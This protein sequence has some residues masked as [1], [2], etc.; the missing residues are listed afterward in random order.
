MNANVKK[1]LTF[2]KKN[3][4]KTSDSIDRVFYRGGRRIGSILKGSMNLFKKIQ[5][6]T[7]LWYSISFRL[8]HYLFRSIT[9]IKS[10]LLKIHTLKKIP[11]S[12]KNRMRDTF[13]NISQLSPQSKKGIKISFIPRKIITQIHTHLH[14]PS[15]VSSFR[16]GLFYHK[17]K[18]LDIVRSFQTIVMSSF[19]LFKKVTE[20]MPSY[21]ILLSK[22]SVTVY[23][24]VC[25][26]FHHLVNSFF[27]VCEKI[28]FSIILLPIL[29][30]FFFIRSIIVG[31][32]SFRKKIFLV[33]SLS[34]SIKNSI[35]IFIEKCKNNLLRIFSF[36]KKNVFTR[37]IPI[38]DE[39]KK[40]KRNFLFQKNTLKNT[41]RFF[42]YYPKK[43]VCS[44]QKKGIHVLKESVSALASF[45][46][47]TQEAFA[48][49]F[50]DILQIR[51][52]FTYLVKY[53]NVTLH[54]PRIFISSVLQENIQAIH[55][56][57]IQPLT[58][59]LVLTKKDFEYFF[60]HVPSFL[61][62]PF[63]KL[64][65]APLR[66][67]NSYQLYI[68]Q[69]QQQQ[70]TP[71][72]APS[73]T[74][75][76]IKLSTSSHFSFFKKHYLTEV[77]TLAVI[78]GSVGVFMSLFAAPTRSSFP[79]SYQGRLMDSSY[80]P[81]ADSTYYLAFEIYDASSNGNCK[82]RTDS[83][84]AGTCDGASLKAISVTTSRGLFTALLGDGSTF[85]PQIGEDFNTASTSY[86]LQVR[87][88]TDA[89]AGSCET[90][91]P[92]K[93]LSGSLFAYRADRVA[94]SQENVSG[95]PGLAGSYNTLASG[96]FTDSNTAASGTATN[97]IFQYIDQGTLAATNS[98][99][100]TTNAYGMY[101]AGAPTKGTNNTVTNSI[102]LGI[103]AGAV[104]VQTNSYGLYVNTQTGATNNYAAVLMGGS[105]GI[106][107]V[108]PTSLLQVGGINT[109]KSAPTTT[110]AWFSVPAATLTDSST[111]ATS[112]AATATFSSF[113]IP[114]YAASNASVT[115][116]DASNLYI[117]GVPLAGTNV[118]LTSSSGLR[119]A[120]NTSSSNTTSA[121][122][123]YVDAPTGSAT[124]KYAAT[125]ATG[126]VGIGTTSPS[127]PLDILKATTGQ[128]ASMRVENISNAA[129]TF[130]TSSG[131]LS[132]YTG[133]FS[134]TS[135]RSTGAN[136]LTN[137][138][139]Y[140]TASGAQNNYAAI[141]D[142]G[143][144]GI[145][146]TS[147]SAKLH[148]QESGAKTATNYAGYFENISTNSDTDAINKYGIYLTSTGT[149]TG[150]GGTATNN[151]GLYL[152]TPTGAD[153]N[154]AAIFA[155][156]NIGIGI[157]A[158]TALLHLAGSTASVASLRIAS[159]TA[160]TTPNDGDMW[161]DSTQKTFIEYL[162]GINQYNLNGLFS[163]Y[164]TSTASN[165]TSETSV[166]ATSS[167]VGTVTLPANFFVTGKTIH[168][169]ASGYYSTT[170][171]PT[172]NMKINF[173]DSTPTTTQILATGAQTATT[174]ASN[175]FW[176]IDATIT[177]Y[178]TGSTG[179]VMGQAVF[180][181]NSSATAAAMWQMV[182]TTPIT[183]DTTKTQQID[184]TTT[185]GTQSTS[186]TL[187]VTN[188][189][190]EA[191][192]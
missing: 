180:I 134:S 104:G 89:T 44:L 132:S 61:F 80:V 159:G 91:T 70:N 160:P 184:I 150:S 156:G 110:G 11:P 18:H 85:N 107:I 98:S 24:S 50:F 49:T 75:N 113:G 79:I 51:F 143:S 152:N 151:Y 106:G 149:F 10:S 95:T 171:A 145:G 54:K 2:T 155:G 86:Y 26:L 21:F 101:L 63:Q 27:S 40:L 97:M 56:R 72:S 93:Q 116:T 57:I 147:P 41:A 181:N 102:A 123:L 148:S 13:F 190:V 34:R 157:T 126:Y 192:N 170:S 45:F 109:T 187:T 112:T 39:Q 46:D 120:A 166:V 186:N 191:M 14:H 158:P 33:L 5:Q 29:E 94:G 88:C 66:I 178:S 139:L 125:F 30:V 55:T 115:V 100:V 128:T 59:A 142:A 164:S 73:G 172:L 163:A 37:I 182:N 67:Q 87:I 58:H 1:F 52:L 12:I 84:T 4:T 64:Q 103:G 162:N 146:T 31:L 135:T 118:T 133:Y 42:S 92:R 22:C 48:K 78:L 23:H 114:T 77:V 173:I 136:A 117:A 69:V 38:Q 111:S 74:N 127:Y 185:W 167:K 25:S 36:R 7:S 161:Y 20:K 177:A 53:F 131:V 43:I 76:K 141:F 137:I 83:G 176:S 90:L 105:V 130:D 3:I 16:K 28:L 71:S 154:Y 119:I 165:T 60:T 9:F 6:C 168:I 65:T 47:I 144:V 96:T 82:W 35:K 32:F 8:P 68:S 122:G 175:L 174:N 188:V 129:S 17:K 140:A 124:N 99:V 153:N 121:Y 81:K 19:R 179:T 189:T 138:G 15:F 183:I 108:N 62:F 169:K